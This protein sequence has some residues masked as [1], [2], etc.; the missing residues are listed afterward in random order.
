MKIKSCLHT[1]DLLV[2]VAKVKILSNSRAPNVVNFKH[3]Y[4]KPARVLKFNNNLV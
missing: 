2:S 1:R 3:F 4:K